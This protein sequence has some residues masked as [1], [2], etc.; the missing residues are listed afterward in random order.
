VVPLELHAVAEIIEI[1][2]VIPAGAQDGRT[3]ADL[4]DLAGEL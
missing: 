3:G 4:G 2:S 1:V